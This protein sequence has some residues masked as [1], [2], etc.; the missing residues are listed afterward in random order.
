MIQHWI[1]SI[2]LLYM[3]FNLYG[4]INQGLYVPDNKGRFGNTSEIT[5]S[6]GL[7]LDPNG[8]S[9]W[10]HNDQGNPTTRVYK[11]LPT[12]GNTP[13]VLQKQVDVLNV[14]N[15]DWED[16]T[17]DN[18]GN[19]Y[20]CQVGK[21]CNANSD[22]EEC[23][24]RFIFKIHK[25]PFSTLNHPDS[26]SVTP[27]TY[28]FKY[29][30]TGYDI[31]NCDSDDTVFVNC[32]SAIWFNN[33]IYLFSKNIW[34]KYTNNCGGWQ[35][36]YT[37]YFK[38]TLNEGSSMTNPLV[39]QYIGKFKLRM[40]VNELPARYQPTSAAISPDQ[41]I[42]SLT[43][44]GRLWQFRNFAGDQFF[45][46]NATFID[47]SLTGSDTIT[48]GFEGI[49]F[50]NNQYVTLSVDGVNGRISGVNIDSIALWTRNTNDSGYGSLR[51]AV[52]ACSD[53]DTLRFTSH[54]LNDT[55]AL[56]SG[57]VVFQKNIYIN[58]PSGQPLQIQSSS[59]HVFTVPISK[60]VFLKNVNIHCGPGNV[61]GLLNQGVCHLE[62]VNFYNSY[63]G[64][65][66][67]NN[68]N[69]TFTGTC[70]LNR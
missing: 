26:T 66:I 41:T 53:G 44:Y 58:Q 48:R 57:P 38:L 29:P 24:T 63:T 56:I 59:S 5:Q 1:T 64:R 23:P 67:Q 31:N 15:L 21:N 62:N 42:F 52:L 50:H 45:S 47:Y 12:S 61:G 65:S 18:A 60:N 10:T 43:T 17:K 40:S 35:E 16:L 14:T 34:S 37:Y 69:L 28:F 32:E 11:F 2:C 3:S 39:A 4:Q 19:I 13:V 49:E 27:V 22:P 36:G 7:A 6:S 54:V 33:A 25:L 8:T 46:G 68:G 20:L 9:Y 51:N 30:L 70:Q 55:I